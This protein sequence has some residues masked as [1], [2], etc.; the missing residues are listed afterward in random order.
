MTA[1]TTKRQGHKG[2]RPVPTASV[3]IAK[4]FP[5]ITHGKTADDRDT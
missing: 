2:W 4:R 5:L 3:K 1:S